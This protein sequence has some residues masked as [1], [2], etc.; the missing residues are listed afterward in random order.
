VFLN[1]VATF[2]GD[3]KP[4]SWKRRVHVTEAKIETIA[5]KFEASSAFRIIAI[6]AAITSVVTF[7]VWMLS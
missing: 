7:V 5:R 1:E 6:I 3:E 4:K 2:L